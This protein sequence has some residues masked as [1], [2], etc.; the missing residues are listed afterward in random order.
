MT[1]A[2]EDASTFTAK[3]YRGFSSR[4]W[5]AAKRSAVAQDAP[6]KSKRPG[7]LVRVPSWSDAMWLR[8]KAAVGQ[9]PPFPATGGGWLDQTNCNKRLRIALDAAGFDWVTAR[10]KATRP[11]RST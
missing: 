4:S 6:C 10:R 2:R 9:G 1:V 11:R 7:I 5:C 8:R 3:L